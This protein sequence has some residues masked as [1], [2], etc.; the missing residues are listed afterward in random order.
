MGPRWDRAPGSGRSRDRPIGCVQESSS[1]LVMGLLTDE[2]RFELAY[3]RLPKVVSP[4]TPKPPPFITPAL[5]SSRRDITFPRWSCSYL[6]ADIETKEDFTS[7]S[8]R[9]RVSVSKSRLYPHASTLGKPA[10]DVPRVLRD[11]FFRGDSPDLCCARCWADS[12]YNG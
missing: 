3:V 10:P 1:G 6:L 12:T 8:I 4:A 11:Y 5:S 2:L 7:R 9:G